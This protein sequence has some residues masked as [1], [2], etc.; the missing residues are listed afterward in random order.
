MTRRK[1]IR[2]RKRKANERRAAIAP[3]LAELERTKVPPLVVDQAATLF[4]ILMEETNA[5]W[6]D[7]SRRPRI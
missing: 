5:R 7:K 1:R 4:A 2:H 6:S 3:Y